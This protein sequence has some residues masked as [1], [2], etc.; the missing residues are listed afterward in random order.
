M[1][2]GEGA[3]ARHHLLLVLL[4]L[5]LVVGHTVGIPQLHLARPRGAGI[6]CLAALLPP[7]SPQRRQARSSRR[8]RSHHTE[9]QRGAR[10]AG[11][12]RAES[13]RGGGEGTPATRARS[14]SPNHSAAVSRSTGVSRTPVAC[15][16]VTHCD[17]S[18][19]VVSMRREER[20]RARGGGGEGNGSGAGSIPTYEGDYCFCACFDTDASTVC[21]D[22]VLVRR[23]SRRIRMSE[24]SSCLESKP[25]MKA[26]LARRLVRCRRTTWSMFVWAILGSVA[27]SDVVAYVHTPFQR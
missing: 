5:A 23:S 2:P 10:G 20:G 24:A 12:R 27:E 22:S 18:R 25:W 11:G 26:R 21:P 17:C 14:M 7:L 6:V 8:G 16:P 1:P 15:M 4:A 19:L 13:Y 9:R 3:A